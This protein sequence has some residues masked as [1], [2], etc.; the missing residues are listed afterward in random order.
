MKKKLIESILELS[1]AEVPIIL[2]RGG[3]SLA[4]Q[5]GD[6]DFIVPFG[7]SNIV[8]KKIL[9]SFQI[10]GWKLLSFR[11]INY[12]STMTFVNKREHDSIAI[13]ID[14][15]NGLAW[16]GLGTRYADNIF[17]YNIWPN[18]KNEHL[19]LRMVS[20][21]NFL[22]KTMYAGKLSDRD[23]DRINCNWKDVYWLASK[24][25]WD[26]NKSL[27]PKGAN[28]YQKW[29][30]RLQSANLNSIT[31]FFRWY[32]DVVLS[33]LKSRFGCGWGSGLSISLSGMDGSGKST[34]YFEIISWYKK[35]GMEQP[36]LIHF[37]P[38]F[39]PLPHQLFRRKITQKKYTSPY[40]EPPVKNALSILIR[41]IWYLLV[42]FISKLYVLLLTKLGNV[43]LSDRSFID[44]CADLERVKIPHV[45][46]NP[47]LKKF[48]TIKGLNFYLDAEPSTVVSR[49]GEL[50]IEKAE[51][52]KN[53]YLKNIDQIN[54]IKIDGDEPEIDVSKS[55]LDNID[56]YYCKVIEAKLGELN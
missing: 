3:D 19:R 29:A 47:L 32:I 26:I 54:G 48:L 10:N 1:S 55:I 36:Y 37:V 22:H 7:M 41:K 20:A 14:I 8:C 34:Q 30:L 15:F 2:L 31:L 52:L 24:L 11:D 21:I 25:D 27:F 13:K 49:K 28:F 38:S 18:T 42:F 45:E 40:S 5:E 44:F 4:R 12:L 16:R 9:L 46:I 6:L 51:S 35:S 50:N 33:A 23:K 43:V 53:R 56:S 17:F 39:I